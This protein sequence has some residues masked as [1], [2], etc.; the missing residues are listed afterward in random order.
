[1]SDKQLIVF[2]LEMLKKQDRHLNLARENLKILESHTE[3]L[4]RNSVTLDKIQNT[5]NQLIKNTKVAL[6]GLRQ[7]NIRK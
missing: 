5:L 1:M 2:M 7:V 3:I 6:E 4:Y